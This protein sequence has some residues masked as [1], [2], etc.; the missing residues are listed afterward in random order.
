MH[1]EQH[2]ALESALS[3]FPVKI[4]HGYF[5]N[6]RRSALDGHIDGHPFGGFP[7]HA[8]GGIDFRNIAAVAQN[9]LHITLPAGLLPGRFQIAGTPGY[10]S[11]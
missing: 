2:P 5:N 7:H 4:Y 10:F 8:V 6:I 9:G 1:L 3:H 11:K